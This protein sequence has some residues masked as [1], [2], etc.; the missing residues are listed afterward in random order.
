MAERRTVL[1][2]VVRDSGPPS[3]AEAAAMLGIAEDDLSRDF[4]VVAIDPAKGSYA[5]EVFEDRLPKGPDGKTR[6]G[7]YSNPPIEPFGPRRK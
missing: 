3:L 2:T 6:G 5:V 4:G 7:P 1:M